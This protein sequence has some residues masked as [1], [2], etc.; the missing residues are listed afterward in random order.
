MISYDWMS[1]GWVSETNS[2]FFVDMTPEGSREWGDFTF[3]TEA[4]FWAWYNKD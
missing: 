1:E 4:D 2:D 3:A